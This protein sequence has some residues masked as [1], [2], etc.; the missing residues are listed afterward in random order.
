MTKTS[1]WPG[2]EKSARTFTRPEGSSSAPAA[3]ASALPRDD[4]FTP[5]A[6]TT[7]RAVTVSIAS[8]RRNV[9]EPGAP[10]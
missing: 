1:G 4:P 10:P 3:M 2:S 5:A 9:T 6:Q 8:P 7:V